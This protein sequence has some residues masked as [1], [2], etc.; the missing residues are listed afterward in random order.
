LNLEYQLHLL[1]NL[2][3]IIVIQHR[4]HQHVMHCLL[5]M[6]LN[7]NNNNFIHQVFVVIVMI[8]HME[9]LH[10][11]RV[12]PFIIIK[13]II[14]Q[15]HHFMNNHLK[16]FLL[17]QIMNLVRFITIVDIHMHFIVHLHHHQQHHR[18]SIIIIIMIMTIRIAVY[19][20]FN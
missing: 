9:Q 20:M 6:M 8:V 7:F 16:N 15:H 3:Q 18:L 13:I 1:Q 17:H 19:N 10:L 14:L 12:V 4:F 11:L 5:K 2:N